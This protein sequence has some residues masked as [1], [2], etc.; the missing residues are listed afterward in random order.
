LGPPSKKEKVTLVCLLGLL[1][2][3]SLSARQWP[4]EG[5]HLKLARGSHGR[6]DYQLQYES[7]H[8]SKLN[9]E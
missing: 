3:F 4:S 8:G 7:A 2:P 1:T 9:S 6:T 5:T